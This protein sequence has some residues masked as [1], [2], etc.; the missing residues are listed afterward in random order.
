MN[1]DLKKHSLWRSPSTAE[2]DSL[3]L[4]SGRR[5]F[6]AA[7]QHIRKKIIAADALQK[8]NICVHQW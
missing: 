2:F 3:E 1:V 4:A 6:I 7:S 5:R 8:G